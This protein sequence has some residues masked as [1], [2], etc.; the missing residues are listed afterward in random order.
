MRRST[1][2]ALALATALSLAACSD[3]GGVSEAPEGEAAENALTQEQTAELLLTEEEFPIDGW[4]RGEVEEVEAGDSAGETASDGD[5]FNDL[6]PDTE[7]IPRE[8]LD[9]LN[10]VGDL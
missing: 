3:D 8:C 10:R 1:T 7:G 5:S 4:T 2:I 9:A 6:F